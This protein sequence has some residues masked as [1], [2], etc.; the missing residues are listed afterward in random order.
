M[1]PSD[2]D[3]F[4]LSPEHLALSSSLNLYVEDIATTLTKHQQHTTYRTQA[5]MKSIIYGVSFLLAASGAIAS[6]VHV[7]NEARDALDD[8]DKRDCTGNNCV[9]AMISSSAL[10]TAFCRTYTTAV[11]A[12]VGPTFSAQCTQGAD[13]ASRACSCQVPPVRYFTC[14]VSMLQL[15]L[16]SF[17]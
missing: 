6:F 15:E 10:A 11:V 3:L 5:N 1:V 16:T 7:Q 9:R 8:L 2:I 17:Q 13:Q 4:F 14:G 12:T